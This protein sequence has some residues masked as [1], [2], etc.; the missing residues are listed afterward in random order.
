[1]HGIYLPLLLLVTA[2]AGFT[3][4]IRSRRSIELSSAQKLI[5]DNRLPND[6]EPTSYILDLR[7]DLEASTFTGKI[8][9]N[10]TWKAES[11]IIEL[12][13]NYELQ[14]DES[15]VKVR[16]IS[17]TE[18]Y[19]PILHRFTFSSIVFFFI[20]FFH[21]FYFYLFYSLSQ[22][23]LVDIRRTDRLPKRPVFQVYLKEPLKNGTKCELEINFNG[24][25]WEQAEGLF[26]TSYTNENG[27]KV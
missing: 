4:A 13:S 17:D 8:R 20:I 19:V 23:K 12:H 14:I 1:M 22:A 5:T 3:H 24:Q 16:L 10:L 21:C 27:V 6:I 26:K 15:N 2:F 18:P 11:K 25:I 9:M 7:P